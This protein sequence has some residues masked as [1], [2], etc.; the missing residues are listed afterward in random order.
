[1]SES[2]TIFVRKAVRDS[3][4]WCIHFV[5]NPYSLSCFNPQSPERT[6][7]ADVF[8]SYARVDKERV[9]PLVAAIE[10]QGWSVWWDATID[11]GQHFDDRIEAELGLAKAVLVVWTVNSVG[12]RWV[13]GEAREAADRGKLVPV[14]FDGASLPM[15]VRAIHTIDLDAWG[16]DCVSPQFQE[17]ARSLSGMIGRGGASDTP[18]PAALRGA[19]D[20]RGARP[21]EARVGIC[22]LPFSNMSGDAEQEYF[23]DGISE[24]IITDLSKVSA[25]VVTSRNSAFKYKGAAADVRRIAQELNVSHVLEGSVRK[26]GSRVR[27]TAQLVHGITN[28]SVWA[29]RYD[30]ELSDIFALQDEI[31]QAIVQALKVKLLPEEKEAIYRRGTEDIEAYNHYLMARQIYITEHSF[32]ERAASAI[33]RLCSRATEID[34]R[35]ARAWALMALGQHRLRFV[36]TREVEDGLVA[37]ERALAL[38]PGLAEA[39]VVRGA[40]LAERG[41]RDEAEVEISSALRLEPESWEVNRSAGLFYFQQARFGEAIQYLEKALGLVPAD[42]G[43]ASLLISCHRAMGNDDGV[44]RAARR[45]LAIADEALRSDPSSVPMI[46]DG[47]LALAAMGDSRRAQERMAS[48]L[49][50]DADNLAMR[51]NFACVLSIHLNDPVGALDML[52]PVFQGVAARFIEFAKMDPDLESLREH[53]R[54]RSMLAEAEARLAGPDA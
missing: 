16:G 46:A 4:S 19:T 37:A 31:S 10:A 51:Y 28:D 14:R 52:E 30:R 2:P 32:T 1:M 12:S 15:D 43:S 36:C 21:P 38:D 42:L 40:I 45:L 26:A 33:I 29:E 39:V 35:Y 34:P 48:A 17:L 3:E 13:R 50:L 7:M 20:A 9:A 22:V 44:Q 41:R 11:A 24:D 18:T 49:L 8:V 53:P 54:F 25:L 5:S 27:I 47:A 23:S 6:F